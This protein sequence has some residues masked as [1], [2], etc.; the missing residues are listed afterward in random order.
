M[1]KSSLESS[2]LSLKLLLPNNADTKLHLLR[3]SGTLSIFQPYA[4]ME[5]GFPCPQEEGFLSTI[6]EA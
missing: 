1:P 6:L 2:P 5:E 3:Q 4:S